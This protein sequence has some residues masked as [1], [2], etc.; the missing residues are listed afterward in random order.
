MEATDPEPVQFEGAGVSLVGERWVGGPEI[1]L[2]LHG[3]GQTRHS[4]ANVARSLAAA[5]WTAIALDA[6]GHGASEWHPDGDYTLNGFVDDLVSFGS[7]LPRAPHLVGA[8]LGGITALIA[9]GEHPGFARSLTLVDVVVRP[10]PA[11]VARIREFMSAHLDGFASLDEA[12]DAVAAYSSER[13]RTRNLDGLRKNVRLAPDGRWYWHWDPRFIANGD[14]PRRGANAQRLATA[15][16]AVAIPT[17]ILRGARSDVVSDEGLAETLRLM[18]GAR[19]ASVAQAG[20]MVAGD[21]NAV[22]V[23]CLEEFLAEVDASLREEPS[24]T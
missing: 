17:L 6:R 4:W 8:S 23:A 10:E 5:G 12:A 11:G 15:A 9:A 22:F 1:V 16:A 20:H 7:A 3:G 13:R 19:T 24:S 21:D 14:E 18:P 2:L